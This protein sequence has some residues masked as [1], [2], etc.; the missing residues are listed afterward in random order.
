MGALLRE[1]LERAGR[2]KVV[3][4]TSHIDMRH[5]PDYLLPTIRVESV[6]VRGLSE[7]IREL[8]KRGRGNGGSLVA[9]HSHR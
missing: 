1:L 3:V 8:L 9:S 4:I 6:T 2:E 5:R 7:V